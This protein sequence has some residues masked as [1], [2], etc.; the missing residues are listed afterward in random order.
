M[1]KGRNNVPSVARDGIWV[2]ITLFAFEKKLQWTTF[3]R[4]NCAYLVVLL[5]VK[6][7][8]YVIIIM[9]VERLRRISN[10]CP[11]C[12][13]A[14]CY[15]CHN[16]VL[17]VFLWSC[18]VTRINVVATVWKTCQSYYR[19]VITIVSRH[20][21]CLRRAKYLEQ[22]ANLIPKTWPLCRGGTIN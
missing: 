19:G 10:Y 11:L 15:Y 18:V 16:N 5:F 21:H 22:Q 13:W 7:I 6:Y 14:Y 9:Y 17:V 2:S 20:W 12:K 3:Y 4:N 1:G 8:F